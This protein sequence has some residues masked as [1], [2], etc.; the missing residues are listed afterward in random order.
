VSVQVL[1]VLLEA[2]ALEDLAGRLVDAL[3]ALVDELA[4]M[5]ARLDDVLAQVVDRAALEVAVGTLV[6][7]LS[8]VAQRVP[9]EVALDAGPELALIAREPLRTALLLA[10]MGRLEVPAG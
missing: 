3:G 9:A 10:G 8:G 6:G 2:V 7:L 1:L 4:G 5:L